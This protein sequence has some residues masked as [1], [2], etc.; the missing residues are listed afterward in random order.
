MKKL[1]L[2]IFAF[3]GIVSLAN[4]QFSFNTNTTI[5]QVLQNANTADQDTFTVNFNTAVVNSNWRPNY[6]IVNR[7]TVNWKKCQTQKGLQVKGF[8]D[9]VRT[10]EY[11]FGTSDCN[12]YGAN[13]N[14]VHVYNVDS[15]KQ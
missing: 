4:A 14:P 1:L 3:V 11:K 10:D 2:S 7:D 13:R 15:L 12:N 8:L 5:G 6:T 9:A